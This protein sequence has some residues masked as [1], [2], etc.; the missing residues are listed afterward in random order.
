MTNI[1]AKMHSYFDEVSLHTH[2]R[3]DQAYV[4]V[5]LSFPPRLFPILFLLTSYMCI[6]VHIIL[7]LRTL[8]QSF[9][10]LLVCQYIIIVSTVIVSYLTKLSKIL[11]NKE[12]DS[13]ES[14]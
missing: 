11:R 10:C 7:I 13:E 6:Y 14:T 12:K 3:R 9:A 5:A 8:V 4:R 1:R 2:E